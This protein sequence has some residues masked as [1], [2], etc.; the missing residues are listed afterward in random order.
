MDK[1]LLKGLRVLETLA[2]SPKPMGVTALSEELGLTKSNT[3]R[4]LQTLIAAGYV[5]SNADTASYECTLKLFEIA[6]SVVSRLDVRQVADPYLQQ[7]AHYTHETIHLSVLD[8]LEVIYINKV[9]SSKPVRAY[10]MIGGR[11][12]AYC[13]A[14]GKALLA[15][16]P[17]ER[18]NNI[19]DQ[20]KQWTPQ[21]LTSHDDLLKDLEKTRRRG[22]SINQGEWRATVGGAAAVIFNAH[23]RPIA[24]IGI[25]GPLEHLPPEA[26]HKY[27]PMVTRT[28]RQLSHA[29][30]YCGNDYPEDT[31]A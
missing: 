24:S 22:F 17:E 5:Y 7:L 21:T 2:A 23:N 30:G 8:D 13:V 4:T 11:A 6:N 25:T 29:L 26:L 18:I 12:P 10:T 1:T 19:P 16:Q 14:T 20:L 15:W 3:H 31:A 28:A 9:E 27:G